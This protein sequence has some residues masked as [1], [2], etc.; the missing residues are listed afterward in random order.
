MKQKEITL[1]G[2]PVTLGYCFATEI[3]YKT[4]SEESIHDFIP[5]SIEDLKAE[6]MPDARKSVFLIL[7][8][9]M[10]YYESRGEKVPVDDKALMYE[11]TP[12]EIGFAIGTVLNLYAEFYKPI[13]TSDSDTTPESSESSDDEHPNA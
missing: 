13:D 6:R 12:T 3:A 9:L 1:C 7:A 5:Q 10:A 8:A 2:K 11:S 4:L